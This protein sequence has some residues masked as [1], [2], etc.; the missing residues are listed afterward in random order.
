[1]DPPGITAGVGVLVPKVVGDLDQVQLTPLVLDLSGDLAMASASASAQA[2]GQDLVLGLDMGPLE[3]PVGLMAEVTA[4]GLDPAALK[5]AI[6]Q[7]EEPLQ[8]PTEGSCLRRTRET[9]PTVGDHTHLL[10]ANYCC[11]ITTNNLVCFDDCS[12][13][14]Y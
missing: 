2:L 4:L 9:G 8:A 1:M 5:V 7:V 11:Y 14:S 6:L 13:R 3:V 12:T 10:L